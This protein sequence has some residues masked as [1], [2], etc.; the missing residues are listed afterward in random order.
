MNMFSLPV[1]K[2]TEF[3]SFAKCIFWALSK[4]NHGHGDATFNEDIHKKVTLPGR[5]LT[6]VYFAP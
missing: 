4:K 5:L 6:S 2:T 3:R 1:Y